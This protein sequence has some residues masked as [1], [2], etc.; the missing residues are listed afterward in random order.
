[1]LDRTKMWIDSELESNMLFEVPKETLHNENKS[2]D[3][4]EP[5]LTLEH[6]FNDP[7]SINAANENPNDTTDVNSSNSTPSIR[8]RTVI[9]AHKKC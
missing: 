5:L 6:M 4:N 1:M 2:S 8:Q 9:N 7:V 3:T